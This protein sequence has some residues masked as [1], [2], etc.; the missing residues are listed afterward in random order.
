MKKILTLLIFTVLLSGAK[1][2][3][4]QD[5]QQ[6][7]YV[8]NL[9]YINPAYAGY[10]ENLNFH[11]FYRSQWTGINGGPVSS[12]LAV[13]DIANDGKVGLAFQVATDKLGAQN[14]L[15][16]Y[17]NYA[18]RLRMNESGSSRLALGFGIG[19][20]NP[21]INGALLDPDDPEPNL[22]TGT[23][24]RILPDGRIGAFYSDD[25]FFAGISADNLISQYINVKNDSYLAQ[26]KPHYYITS[27]V[28]IPLTAD[29]MVKPSIMLKD[30]RGGPTSLDLNAFI[31]FGEKIWLGGSYRTGVKLY[32]KSYLQ[33]N[34]TQLNS[35]TA[36]VE[37]FPSENLRI[38][39]AYDFSVGPLQGYSGGTH[40]I[41]IGFYIRKKNSRMLSPRYF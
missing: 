11:A 34:L 10:K 26:P 6:S 12:S 40:E 37:F 16:A 36:A 33:S 18:Y 2:Y 19:F 30:D 5:V 25:S 13:D 32:S 41:S 28:L 38:G 3:A 17:V 8:F 22:P 39:Y 15:S 23:E 4:Q 7:Q 31:L 21:S 24:S 14:N 27:G 1:L 9:L 20:V 35:A 29:I